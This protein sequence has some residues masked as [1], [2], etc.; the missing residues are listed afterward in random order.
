MFVRPPDCL[1][2][3]LSVRPVELAATAL[4][5][6]YGVGEADECPD[7][8]EVRRT[9]EL[10]QHELRCMREQEGA[11]PNTETASQDANTDPTGRLEITDEHLDRGG[12]V[13]KRQCY[14]CCRMIDLLA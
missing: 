4:F 13:R 10:L 12:T 3:S 6:I 5:L 1:T 2:N 7:A 14:K 8:A 9:L 11:P